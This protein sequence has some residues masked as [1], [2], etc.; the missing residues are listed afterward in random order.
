M[1]SN[2]G[3]HALH[4]NFSM[5]GK[6]SRMDWIFHLKKIYDEIKKKNKIQ[7]ITAPVIIE[8]INTNVTVTT[9]SGH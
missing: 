2:K 4:K 1:T 7:L 9:S 6:M 3:D 8:S 5:K